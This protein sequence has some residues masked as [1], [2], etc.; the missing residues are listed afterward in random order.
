MEALAHTAALDK[1]QMGALSRAGA[2]RTLSGNRYQ[3]AAALL[4]LPVSVD[5]I[6]INAIS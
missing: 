5:Q 3:A 2:L 1:G 4:S 6:I